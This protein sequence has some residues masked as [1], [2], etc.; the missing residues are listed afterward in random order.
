MCIRVSFIRSGDIG[1]HSL[2][3][4]DCHWQDIRSG[5]EVVWWNLNRREIPST[6][7]VDR[8]QQRRKPTLSIEITM[9]RT[10]MTKIGLLPS[11]GSWK[12]VRI[13]VHRFMRAMED[14]EI[15]ATEA[16]PFFSRRDRSQRT[17]KG[18]MPHVY[19]RFRDDDLYLS[20]VFEFLNHG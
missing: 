6:G 8:Y 7:V 19:L 2:V 12:S 4:V 18:Q 16:S 17:K 3:A 1:L 14:D 11:S 9:R 20:L 10:R 15:S 13:P 5:E